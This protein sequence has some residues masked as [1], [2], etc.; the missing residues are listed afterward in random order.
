[1]HRNIETLTR[2]EMDVPMNSNV[3]CLQPADRLS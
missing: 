3:I 1:M 2:Y